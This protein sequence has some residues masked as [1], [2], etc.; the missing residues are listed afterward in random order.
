MLARRAR[1]FTLVELIVVIVITGILA[2]TLIMYFKP[3]LQSYL[4]VGRRAGMTD[5]A[6]GAVRIMSRDIRSAVSNSVRLIS[7][8]CVEMVPASDGGRFRAAPDTVWDAANPGN[9]SM[10]IDGSSA[11]TAFD[12]LTPFAATPTPA[13]LASD[14]VVI[15][16]QNTDD[17][18]TGANRAAIASVGNAPATS[19]G[20]ARITLSSAKQFPIGYDGARFVIV[21][22]AQ[23]AV[24]YVC[25]GVGIDADGTGTGILYRASAYGFNSVASCPVV[26]SGT[27]IVATKIASCGFTYSANQ[28]AT[29]Q[30]GYVEISLKL[31][32]HGES[33]TLNFGA[34]V[35]NVP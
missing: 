33:A 14:F 27:A 8:T 9:P 25:S 13:A 22:N 4:D 16:N 32:D 26:G 18:Y 6:D 35:D 17:V 30:S 23:Q 31:A 28:G 3:A 20:A 10:P 24:S 2:G 11:V 21:P 12:V 15:D 19:V 5:M 1:G 7:G 34:H 29:Q